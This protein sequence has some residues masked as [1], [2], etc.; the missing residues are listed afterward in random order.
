MTP[1]SDGAANDSQYERGGATFG[2]GEPVPASANSP[3]RNWDVRQ[4]TLDDTENLRNF[5]MQPAPREARVIQCYIKR[6]KS[7]MNR[8]YPE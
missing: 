7:A 1:R 6:S 5:L 3:N 4:L 2:S 8:M